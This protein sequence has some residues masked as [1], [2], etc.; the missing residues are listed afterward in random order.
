MR[1]AAIYGT[2]AALALTATGVAPASSSPGDPPLR[3]QGAR[4]AAG[5]ARAAAEAAATGID[6]K[7]CPAVE[8]LD[9]PVQCGKV[10]VPVDYTEPGGRK[11]RLTV[12]RG[13]A[14][15]P[16]AD[17]QGPLL[18]NPGGPGSSGMPFPVF[19]TMLGG[20]WKKLNRAYDFVGYAPRGV[21]RSAPLTCRGSKKAGRG[22][23]RSPREPSAAFKRKMRKQAAAY[24]RGCAKRQ[25][26][27]L[28]HYTTPDNA[29]DLDVLRAALGSRR[30]NYL[31]ASWGSYVGSVYATLFPG[32]V[33]RLVLDSVVDPSPDKIWYQSNLD[34]NPAFE[35]R[36]H[37][38]KSWVAEHHS[39]YRLGRNARAVQRTFDRARDAVDRRPVGG[40]VGRYVGSKEL[41]AGFLDVAY[42]DRAWAGYAAALA[43]FRRGDP[44]PLMGLVAPKRGGAAMAENANAVYNAVQCSDARWPRAWS[45]WDRDNTALARRAPFNTWENAWMNLPCAYWRGR[46]S[47]PLDVGTGPGELPAVLLL[48]STRDAATPYTGAV[49]TWKRLSGSSLVTERG[50]GTHGVADGNACADRHLTAYLLDGKTPGRAAECAARPA[51]KPGYH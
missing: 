18:Y 14:T 7:K 30:L 33:R 41:L 3:R 26:D 34:Q 2:L 49:E 13:R 29:R 50:G 23:T 37:D 12:S 39:R 1:A 24:A 21:G 32:H 35:R 27:R 10:T 4:E 9:A 45:R 16:A 36:W 25:G 38:W 42:D 43:D 15:G 47:R 48:A 44:Q 6:W 22:P 17:R 5:A 46:Q 8:Q 19:G 20:V 11:I 51:P 31:G 28:D 40:S